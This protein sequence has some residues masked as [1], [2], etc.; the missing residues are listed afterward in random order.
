MPETEEEWEVVSEGEEGW[1]E[2]PENES[3]S[4]D[5]VRIST[6]PN[7]AFEVGM[8][9]GE[10]ASKFSDKAAGGAREALRSIGTGEKA[11]DAY[12]RGY[13]DP[14]SSKSVHDDYLDSY[15]ENVDTSKESKL[16]IAGPIGAPRQTIGMAV[17]AA[18]IAS[19][20]LTNPKEALMLAAF[21]RFPTLLKQAAP[22]IAQK[23]AQFA[24]KERTIESVGKD[25]GKE[26]GNVGKAIKDS[27]YKVTEPNSADIA[28]MIKQVQPDA[29][30]AAR[31]LTQE[32][33][34]EMSGIRAKNAEIQNGLDT[35]LKTLDGD[36]APSTP[37]F[38]TI[39]KASDKATK[40]VREKYWDYAKDLSERYGVAY[41]KAIANEKI[42]ANRLYDSL[43]NSMERDGFLNRPDSQWSKSQKSVYD[44]QQKVKEFINA[45][46]PEIDPMTNQVINKVGTKLKLSQVDKD[47]RN[48]LDIKKGK[49]YTQGDHIL[50]LTREET[51]K[52]IG[53][54]SQKV[55]S[56]QRMFA[57]ELQAKNELTKIVQPFN[58]SGEFDTTKGINFFSNYAKGTMNNPDEIRLLQVMQTNPKLN[59]D[60]FN[61]LDK[62]NLERNTILRNKIDLQM[63]KPKQ[64]QS[65]QQKYAKLGDTLKKDVSMQYEI[66]QGM[67]ERAV[68]N[69]DIASK[70][71]KASWVAGG[72]AVG[73]IIGQKGKEIVS[74]FI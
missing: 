44:Y 66:L 53:D 33:N 59:G 50:T 47:L 14:S 23:I 74:K 4:R 70:I 11:A 57:P 40:I 17:S 43:Q 21:E 37:E 62:L 8:K 63:N 45:S 16:D 32:K 34:L 1:E 46:T 41:E 60:Y 25:L 28:D 12:M 56:V 38:V 10:F 64:F 55:K 67:K 39:P 15:Y 20:I 49:S 36:I 58:R 26:F 71:K 31:V 2:V 13:S 30:E 54:V 68:A 7:P 61:S 35:K 29:Q 42:D 22:S 48:I 24:T 5:K 73:T 65:V 27:K 19:D 3:P 69:E 18:G 9:M 51:A 72:A 6:S 52:A